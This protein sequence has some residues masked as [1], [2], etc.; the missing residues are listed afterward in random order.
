[1]SDIACTASFMTM[2]MAE[3]EHKHRTYDEQGRSNRDLY[4]TW[5]KGGIELHIELCQY[6][7]LAEM[8]C[9]FACDKCNYSFTGVY[10]YE[11]SEPFGRWF[12]EYLFEYGDAPSYSDASEKLMRDTA[13]FFTSNSDDKCAA[14]ILFTKMKAEL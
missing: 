1:M 4:T 6:A 9:N 14:G 13:L 12:A 11:V 3:S 2:G 10:D 8:L 5:D 7:Q